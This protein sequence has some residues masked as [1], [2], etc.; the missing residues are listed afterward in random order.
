MPETP[1][2]SIRIPDPVWSDAV[3]T[4]N[5]RGDKLAQVVTE[6][7]RRYVARN[8]PKETNR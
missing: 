4:A 7:L 6:A 8:T 1:P 2:R 3:A 5:A